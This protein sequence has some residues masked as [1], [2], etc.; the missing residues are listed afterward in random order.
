[1]KSFPQEPQIGARG[2]I[3]NR[4]FVN[5]LLDFRHITAIGLDLDHTLAIY[6][7]QVFNELA[8]RETVEY[9]ISSRGYPSSIAAETYDNS[10][11]IRGL[12]ADRENGVLLKP[13]ACGTILSARSP[14]GWMTPETICAVYDGETMDPGDKRYHGVNSPFDLPVALLYHAVLSAISTPGQT[15]SDCGRVLEDVRQMLD[16]S[17]THGR[18]KS[19]IVGNPGLFLRGQPGTAGSLEKLKAAGKKLFLLTNSDYGYTQKVLDY[20]LPADKD[21]SWRALFDAVVVDSGKPGFFSGAAGDTGLELID[22]RGLP[23]FRSGSAYSLEQHLRVP[24]HGVLYIGD[25]PADDC[26]AGIKHGWSVAMVVPEIE[27][28]GSAPVC[29][30][31]DNTALSHRWGSVFRENGRLTRFAGFLASAPHLY[32]AGVHQIIEYCLTGFQTASPPR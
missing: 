14:E 21:R 30:A 32:A 3:T 5:R 12:Y 22:S 31:T 1:M 25:N 7:D 26:A 29:E 17:H 18:L 13:D 2:H 23:V 28:E 16:E 10:L 6:N 15:R 20:I 27:H 19:R 9:L 11:V 4:V 8:F 24:K